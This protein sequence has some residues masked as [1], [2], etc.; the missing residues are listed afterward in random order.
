MLF[1]NQMAMMEA[2]RFADDQGVAR[3]AEFDISGAPAGSPNEGLPAHDLL[4]PA[5]SGLVWEHYSDR[6]PMFALG[7]RP[8]G[9]HAGISL[10]LAR[11][12]RARDRRSGPNGTRDPLA[13][14]GGMAWLQ[15]DLGAERPI[16]M[17][18]GYLPKDLRFPLVECKDGGWIVYTSTVRA[19]PTPST[20]ARDHPVGRIRGRAEASCA[21]RN[22]LRRRPLCDREGKRLDLTGAAGPV[23][24]GRR[25]MRPRPRP[26]RVL[27]RPPAAA[28]RDDQ[29][30]AIRN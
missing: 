21:W 19:I 6:P 10:L 24:G 15:L 5:S 4:A 17:L 28:E 9:G 27:G 7:S 1:A 25:G 2:L 26:H 23:R 22:L 30:H 20:V 8:T 12:A 16:P 14:S 11:P 29:V 3:E 18:Q 13:W